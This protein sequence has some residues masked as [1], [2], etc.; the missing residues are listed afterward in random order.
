[1][2]LREAIDVMTVIGQLAMIFMVIP[3]CLVSAGIILVK[4]IKLMAEEVS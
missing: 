4:L 1:M 3:A 2:T